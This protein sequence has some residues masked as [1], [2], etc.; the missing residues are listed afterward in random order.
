[1][2]LVYAVSPKHLSFYLS[3]NF[4]VKDFFFHPREHQKLVPD[5][6]GV[7]GRCNATLGGVER[8]GMSYSW[9]LMSK[10]IDR[11]FSLGQ[12]SKIPTA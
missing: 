4:A 5:R 1:M 11:Y 8:F 10:L 6:K 3:P 12:T 9:L 7:L 2:S